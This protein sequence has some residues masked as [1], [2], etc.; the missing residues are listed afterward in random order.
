MPSPTVREI[1]AAE[2]TV[3][4]R[5]DRGVVTAFVPSLEP[6]APVEVTFAGTTATAFWPDMP[7]RVLGRVRGPQPKQAAQ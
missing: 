6:G 7:I 2:L 1:P 4:D 3:G 5:T